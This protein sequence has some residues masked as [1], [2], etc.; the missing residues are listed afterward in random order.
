MTPD[1]DFWPPH[2]QVHAHADTHEHALTRAHSHNAFYIFC[3][4]F[5]IMLLH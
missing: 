2:V 1:F 3:Y 4:V 5:A